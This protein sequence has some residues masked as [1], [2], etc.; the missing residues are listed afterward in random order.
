MNASSE[1]RRLAVNG[2][3]Y[4]GRNSVNANSAVIITITPEDYGDSKDPLSG[5]AFQRKL[6][7]KAYQIGN[8]KVPVER[9]GSFKRAILGTKAQ[10]APDGAEIIGMEKFTPCIK[11]QW[12]EAP[13]HEILPDALNRAFVEGME[14]FGRKIRGFNGD[15]VF[16]EGIESRTSSPVRIL[17][18]E[19][20]QSISAEGLYPC[21]E[22]AGYAGGITSAAMDGIFV[23]E[24]LARALQ[25]EV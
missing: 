25:E 5:V 13:V 3:S 22:G 21:G 14:A 8:G 10:E 16:V 2:M 15:E 6:E 1:E 17:R 11:G 23:A 19:L 24:Q 18:N 20:A 7:E 12:T 9:Y 4:S